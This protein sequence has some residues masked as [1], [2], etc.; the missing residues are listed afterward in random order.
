MARRRIVTAPPAEWA[1]VVLDSQGLR[2]I[3]S[4]N[5]EDVRAVVASSKAGYVR[6]LV[7]TAVLAE[8]LRGNKSDAPL[9][10]VTKKIDVVPLT[11]DLARHAANLKGSA[12]LSGVAATVDAIVVATS[13][14]SRGGLIITSD[15]R[16]IRALAARV[17][18]VKIKVLTV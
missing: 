10:Q 12:G 15:P 17:V 4:N 8:T 3:A 13:A 16:D 9:N 5:S 11:E 18:G 14:A 7:P 1:A 6:I 2:A